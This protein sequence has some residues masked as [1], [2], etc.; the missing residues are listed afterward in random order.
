MIDPGQDLMDPDMFS[1]PTPSEEAEEAQLEQSPA[2][3]GKGPFTS[4]QVALAMVRYQTETEARL[5]ATH[6]YPANF[7]CGLEVEVKVT[8]DREGN[9]VD[10][11]LLNG[12]GNRL[13]DF[14]VLLGL[15][16]T[17]F[18][19]IP[20]EVTAETITQRMVF[21]SG[22]NCDHKPDLPQ[23]SPNRPARPDIRGQARMGENL[24]VEEANTPA[25]QV[26]ES[27]PSETNHS[28]LQGGPGLPGMNNP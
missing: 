28:L 20:E 10:R 21:T 18:P 23:P 15:R 3:A 7:A 1:P 12:S 16:R 22:V 6:N 14:A 25:P 5:R 13:Y 9:L 4:G 26:I 24:H 27:A 11:E 17:R 19:A 2:G 8:V